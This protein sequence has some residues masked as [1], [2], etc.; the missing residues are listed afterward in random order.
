MVKNV[1]NII[2]S[3]HDG[4]LERHVYYI[5]SYKFSSA[6]NH[7]VVVLTGYNDNQLTKKYE[8][9]GF[10]I[11]YFDFD[12]RLFSFRSIYKNVLLSL[13]LAKLIKKQKI[14]VI[15]SHDFF[16]ALIARISA[17]ASFFL[18]FHRVK[19]IYITLH[20]VFLWFSPVHNFINR[21]LGLVTSRIVCL[22]RAIL[23]YSRKHDKIPLNKYIIIHTGVDTTRFVP[24]DSL[25]TKYLNEFNLSNDDFVLGNIG[26]LS[27]RKGQIYLLEAFNRLYKEYPNLKLLI[28][29]SEREHELDIRD[30]IYDFINHNNL[31]NTVKIIKPRE[32][33]NY[34][35]NLFDIFIMPSITEGLSACAIEALLMERICLFSDIEPFRELVTDGKN[36]FLF[37]NKDSND[38][39]NKLEY[40][41]NHY[42]SLD[43]VKKA[44][45]ESVEGR[46]DVRNMVQKYEDLYLS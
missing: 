8:S 25:K 30:N 37:K 34:I 42:K 24:D 15:H 20:I 22:S 26:V 45:R 44:A 31:T 35:Y 41:I 43:C 9:L 14:N 1:L 7:K 36:G 13:K 16:P 40:I 21:L 3:I 18:F 5:L 46:F 29:G 39:K 12:N 38:L 11:I 6:L 23:N 28:F 10:E 4:G 2:T 32:D 33:I 27:V 17:L 19:R